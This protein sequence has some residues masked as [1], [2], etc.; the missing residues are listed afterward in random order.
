MENMEKK[1]C[2]NCCWL[3]LFFDKTEPHTCDFSHELGKAQ[4]F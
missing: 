1:T 3:E 4:C 2:D